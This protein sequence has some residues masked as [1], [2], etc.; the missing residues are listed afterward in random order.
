[1]KYNVFVWYWQLFG[2]TCLLHVTNAVFSG[3]VVK[4]YFIFVLEIH[5]S[6][7]IRIIQFFWI[8]SIPI[9]QNLLN[10]TNR[11]FNPD[12]TQDWILWSNPNSESIFSS[13]EQPVFKIWSNPMAK[14]R[15]DYFWTIG[16]RSFVI[17]WQNTN[18]IERI[19][20]KSCEFSNWLA[21][22]GV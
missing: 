18:P 11:A 3:P 21:T 20:P 13:F 8:K 6:A 22:T 2:D 7:G 5:P 4:F 16:P 17:S 9:F 12:Q 10:N 19:L 14:I 15:S 1:M